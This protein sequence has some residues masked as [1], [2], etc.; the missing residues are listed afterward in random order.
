MIVHDWFEVLMGV[1]IIYQ[2]WLLFMIFSDKKR[3]RML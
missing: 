3:R 1:S 2:A